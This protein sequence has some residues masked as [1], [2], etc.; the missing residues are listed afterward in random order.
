MSDRITAALNGVTDG[1]HTATRAEL[2]DE[3]RRLRELLIAARLDL[4]D[5]ETA[6]W[7]DTPS[8]GTTTLHNH[9]CM[10]WDEYVEFTADPRGFVRRKLFGSQ[11]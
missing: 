3:I 5:V 4:V 8:D 7:H 6:Y 11:Q 1:P 2:C 9:L 10:T